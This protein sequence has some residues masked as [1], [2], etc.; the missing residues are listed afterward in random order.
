MDKLEHDPKTKQQIKDQLFGYIYDPVVKQFRTRIDTLIARNAVLGGFSHRH[1]SYK[2]VLY[3]AETTP[4][5]L[6]HNRLMAGLRADMDEYLA[7]QAKLNQQELPYVLGFIN[8]VL[9]SSC[10]LQDYLRILP[11]S[12]HRPLN[13]LA[14]TCPCRTKSLPDEK[15]E[16]LKKRNAEAISLIKQRL[17]TNLL[18]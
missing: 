8:Q 7:D 15:V 10:D 5:P 18:I 17:V 11:D 16:Q 14:A 1:F 6:P 13:E 9:N 3:N 12:I 4:P 2:G